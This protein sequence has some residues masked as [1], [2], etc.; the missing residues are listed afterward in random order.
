MRNLKLKGNRRGSTPQNIEGWGRAINEWLGVAAKV[1]GGFGLVLIVSYCYFDI[2][3]I[4]SGLTL[5]DTFLYV[6]ISLGFGFVLLI[7]SAY[8]TYTFFWALGPLLEKRLKDFAFNLAVILFIIFSFYVYESYLN[9][10]YLW[11]LVVLITIGAAMFFVRKKANFPF[12]LMVKSW[13]GLYL[14]SILLFLLALI[15]SILAFNKFGAEKVLDVWLSALSA[16]V[17]WTFAVGLSSRDSLS[18]KKWNSRLKV[19]AIIIFIFSGLLFPLVHKDFSKRILD[20]TFERFGIRAENVSI[21][22]NEENAKRFRSIFHAEAGMEKICQQDRGVDTVVHGVDVLW[23]G[24]GDKTLIEV[25][26]EVIHPFEPKTKK[27]N[28]KI[29]LDKK[30][31]V[32]LKNI[33]QEACLEVPDVLFESGSDKLQKSSKEKLEPI[34]AKIAVNSS[35]VEKI[36]IVG[37]SD[38]RPKKGGNKALSERRAMHIAEMFSELGLQGGVIK[39]YGEGVL[40]QEVICDKYKNEIVLDECLAPNRRVRIR[41]SLKPRQK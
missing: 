26:D 21:A 1:S 31:V 36:D 38:P 18:S 23:H 32:I 28:A 35:R 25:S 34:L 17:P 19:P 33:E 4:P 6:A 13:N 10:I 39:Y 37:Y 8:S 3:F 40:N 41:I 24:F 9:Y 7:F 22:M 11:V 16:A 15:Y 12:L 30:G 27:E 14:G 2:G 29:D 20:M 5:A